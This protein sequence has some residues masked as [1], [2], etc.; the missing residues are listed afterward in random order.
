MKGPLFV[1]L[2]LIGLIVFSLSACKTSF[3]YDIWYGSS[4]RVGVMVA[5]DRQA[6]VLVI[7][8][9][10]NEVIADYRSVLEKEGQPS[11][12]LGAIQH[13]FGQPG[14]H[15]FSGTTSQWDAVAALLMELEGLSYHGVRPTVEA[16]VRLTI[17]HA[18]HLSKSQA[19]DTLGVLARTKTESEDIEDILRSMEKNKPLVTIYDAGR[20]VQ[21]GLAPDHLRVWMNHWTEL[22]LL[23]ARRERGVEIHD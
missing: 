20:F 7:A 9:I 2:A 16:M 10:P 4:D 13:L 12:T 5:Y 21:P 3:A 18:R 23:E 1:K 19:I 15:F 14:T 22:I 8:T 6:H 11:D 17:A